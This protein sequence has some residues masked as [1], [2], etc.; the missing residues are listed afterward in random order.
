MSSHRY[1][2]RL[3]SSSSGSGDSDNDYRHH[4]HEHHHKKHHTH[5]TGATG[6]SGPT[7]STG[8]FT[9]PTGSYNNDSSDSDYDRRN[10]KRRHRHHTGPTG[11][12]CPCPTGALTGPTGST[13]PTGPTGPTGSQGVSITGATGPTG[14]TGSGSD[15]TR[16]R[17]HLYTTVSQ[18]LAGS[19]GANLPGTSVVFENTVPLSVNNIDIS[20]ANANGSIKFL[21]A[22]LYRTYHTTSSSILSISEPIPGIAF[23]L[24]LNGIY[25]P[26]S[27][28]QTMSI[29]P[30][31]SI[32][33][34][35]GVA[36][37]TVA[38]NDILTV[39]SCSTNVVLLNASTTGITAPSVT[40]SLNILG[41]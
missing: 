6:S 5:F 28:F 4:E 41:L 16:P 40:A 39:A 37:F 2:P 27:C 23:G 34:A 3:D 8:P 36:E 29:S 32:N 12:S 31:S 18:T 33:F 14:A 22:G 25:I 17:A 38:V 21:Q 11:S 26:G 15:I 19:T 9:G 35:G 10:H 24:F 20:M 30:A 7:G 1:R 13:G